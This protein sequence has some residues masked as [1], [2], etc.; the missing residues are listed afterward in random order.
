[1]QHMGTRM[2]T[3]HVEAA[4]GPISHVNDHAPGHHP[5]SEAAV[6]LQQHAPAAPSADVICT[7]YTATKPPA[8]TD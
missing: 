3:R 6:A 4:A 5:A 7:A 8:S 1:M 2:Q